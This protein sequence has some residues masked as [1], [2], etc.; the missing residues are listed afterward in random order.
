M[1]ILATDLLNLFNKQGRDFCSSTLPAI[2]D[3]AIIISAKIFS[4]RWKLY[5]TVAQRIALLSIWKKNIKWIVYIFLRESRRI[6]I[7]N[8]INIYAT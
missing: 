2:V 7:N 3:V 5:G 8:V 6:F 4:A 1:E